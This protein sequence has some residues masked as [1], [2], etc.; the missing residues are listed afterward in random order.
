MNKHT[1]PT[2]EK[3]EQLCRELD[4]IVR[5]EKGSFNSGYCLVAESRVIV[6]NKFFDTDGR[7]NVIMDIL[8][9]ILEDDSILSDKSRQLYRHL[10]KTNESAYQSKIQQ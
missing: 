2:L 4:Y 1:K 3:L 5:Y 8:S 10:L 7:V 6:I 9:V